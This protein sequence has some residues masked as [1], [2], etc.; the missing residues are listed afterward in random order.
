MPIRHKTLRSLAMLVIAGLTVA[1]S[2]A[3]DPWADQRYQYRVPLTVTNGSAHAFSAGDIVAATIPQAV[4]AG[5]RR[6][7]G[8]DVAL[9]QG[10]APVAAKVLFMGG[11]DKIL[12]ALPD[13]LPA[14]GSITDLL[15]YSDAPSV[16]AA[17]DVPVGL[18]VFDFSDA[19]LH[20]WKSLQAPD[21]A[22]SGTSDIRIV[23]VISDVPSLSVDTGRYHHP[24]A[25]ADGMTPVADA[26]VYAS[27]R[28]RGG[29]NEVS[30]LQRFNTQTLTD[31]AGASYLTGADTPAA[32]LGIDA[33]G[34]QRILLTSPLGGPEG[35]DGR[36]HPGPS[37]LGGGASYSA[38]PDNYQFMVAATRDGGSGTQILGKAWQSAPPFAGAA[39]DPV[40]GGFQN[41]ASVGG[42]PLPPGKVAV[43]LYGTT[44]FLHWVAVTPN[45][46]SDAVST[47]AGAPETAPAPGPGKAVVQ[48]VV[49]N[50]Y[51]GTGYPVADAT[52]TVSDAGGATVASSITDSTGRYRFVVPADAT[53]QALTVRAEQH[54]GMG[55]VP[56][57]VTEN[58]TVN[59]DVPL[60][61]A[62]RARGTV[63]DAAGN[64]VAGATV[65]L[66]LDH[67]PYVTTDAAG[68]YEL[69]VPA[70]TAVIGAQ[71]DGTELSGPRWL[72]ASAGDIAA[73]FTVFPSGEDTL[74]HQTPTVSD[75][76]GG[77]VSAITDGSPSTAWTSG[78]VDG[79]SPATPLRLTWTLND[80]TISQIEVH[81][82]HYPSEWR[83]E[84]TNMV[85]NSQGQNPHPDTRVYYSTGDGTPPET[86]GYLAPGSDDRRV[87]V[88]KTAPVWG[89]K[90][91]SIVVTGVADADPLSLYEVT[92]SAPQPTSLAD[93]VSALQIASG[94]RPAPADPNAFMR[95]NAYND[96]SE[97][98]IRDAVQ[99]ARD[100]QTEVK[101]LRVLTINYEPVIEAEGNRLARQVFGWYDPHPQTELHRQDMELASHDFLR[102]NLVPQINVDGYPWFNNG[103]RFDDASFT[104]AWRTRVNPA[105]STDYP[106]IIREFDLVRRVAVGDVDEVWIQAPPNFAMPETIMAGANAYWCNSSPVPGRNGNRLFTFT[107]FNYERYTDVMIHDWG[108]RSESILGMKVYNG[109]NAQSGR[110]TFDRFTRYDKITPGQATA[111]NTHFPPNAT[112]D[113]DY[114]NTTLVS[115]DAD[116]WLNYP[117]LTGARHTVSRKNWSV[118]R[119]T[120]GGD[121]DYQRNYLIWWFTRFPHVPGNGPDGKLANW[122]KYIT[123]MNRYPESR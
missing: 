6:A 70:G 84:L 47:A 32:G 93:A 99:L 100:Q 27:V 21:D 76:G 9:Y 16:T 31:T 50:A 120:P 53:P 13:A 105:G 117:N 112:A 4:L 123:D 38:N 94:F 7:D 52:V 62:A 33:F 20:G 87:T 59:L 2:R 30:L 79:I 107:N 39:A 19:A 72:D 69:P 80:A 49:F 48:G 45:G 37:P 22:N 36:R 122:W 56:G 14:G 12:F 73:D 10:G 71:R 101:P 75:A 40:P 42:A 88:I 115:S 86:G 96:D 28:T 63:T 51:R 44:A 1:A 119:K 11:S 106:A 85:T 74:L 24:M 118:P 78:P 66:F 111:G 67:G 113:Y 83:V 35:T 81:W 41:T 114:A 103:F 61:F 121:I 97:I 68:H 110:T 18:Q 29:D 26:T 54:D 3:A 95:W 92:T 25:F 65:G 34:A 90:T 89:V 58:T 15:L 60:S 17:P 5:R 116:D 64:P 77:D 82:K 98:N 104:T 55:S 102:I 43:M 8:A 23:Q 91:L 108:H 57:S 46:Y 109:W